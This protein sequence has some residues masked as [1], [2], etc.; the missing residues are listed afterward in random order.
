LEG[1]Q[2]G[3]DKE[4]SPGIDIKFNEITDK[5]YAWIRASVNI[6]VPKNSKGGFPLLAI[7]FHHKDAAYKYRSSEYLN[8]QLKKGKWNLVTLEYQT[9]E[10]RNNN[11]NL[12][13]Y[14]WNRDRK[15]VC[16]NNLRIECFEPL[17]D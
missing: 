1:L 9:P 11:D 3:E 8:P 17:K 5:E 12:K 6:F 15:E 4:F 2:L 7:A 10:V 13:V 16:I 14:V